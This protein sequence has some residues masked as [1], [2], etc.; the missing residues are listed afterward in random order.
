MV[1]L[2]RPSLDLN[3]RVACDQETARPRLPV[4]VVRFEL[5]G[6]QILSSPGEVARVER[7]DEAIVGELV[8]P[9]TATGV[10]ADDVGVLQLAQH[11]RTPITARAG[12]RLGS[13]ALLAD[14]GVVEPLAAAHA[15]S[16]QWRPPSM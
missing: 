10:G 5:K 7:G 15:R 12:Q 16:R 11:R 14:Q 8:P 1:V 13:E 3:E 9:G 6:A 2:G 4:P